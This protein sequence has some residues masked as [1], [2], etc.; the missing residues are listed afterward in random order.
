MAQD[1]L[2]NLEFLS[3]VAKITQEIDNHTGLND[4]TLAEFVI[5]LHD[6]SKTLADF[7]AKLKQVGADFPESFVENIDRLVLT[8]HPKHK[9]KSSTEATGEF[10]IDDDDAA[11][12]KDKQK[13]LFPGLA[14]ADQE[15]QPT[16]SKDV[17]MKE[18]DDMMAQFESSAKR[19]KSSPRQDAS[20][21]R[22]QRRTSLSPP[23]R[24]S[25]SPPRGRGYDRGRNGRVRGQLDE[26]PVLYK[27][28]DG[29]VQGLK[30]FGAFVQLEGIA[31]RVEGVSHLLDSVLSSLNFS[32]LDTYLQHSGRCARQLGRRP[33]QQRPTSQD[34]SNERGWQPHWPVYER[35]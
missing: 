26:R 30:E 14:L 24:R 17:I 10:K 23:R 19:T 3:L 28:Y 34:Q 2:Y 25:A 13:R 18:V 11:D 21:P 31:G 32:R 1:D 15:W 5:D 27:I 33:S 7:K 6:Q 20:P 35:R 8:L 4:K 12:E 9:K 29:R 22:K 16:V